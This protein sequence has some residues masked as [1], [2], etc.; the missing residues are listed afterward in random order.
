MKIIAANWKMNCDFDSTDFW[1]DNF[2][3]AYTNQYD[4]MKKVEIV[5]CPPSILL[6]YLDSELT[7]DGLEFLAEFAKKEGRNIDDF[8]AEEINEIVLGS[9]PFKLGGQDCHHE[10]S[11]SF[12]GDTSALMLHN[13]GCQYVILGHSERRNFHFESDQIISKKIKAALNQKIIP[14]ICV[15]E[16]KEIRDQAKHL[17]FVEKQILQSI[18]TDVKFEKLVI[19]YE[20]I[21][22]IG[23]G[24]IPSSTQILEMAN[25]IKKICNEKFTDISQSY[26]TL[27]GGSVSSKNSQEILAIS[28]IDGLLVG[29]ASLDAEEFATICI[30]NIN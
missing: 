29:K 27:Y 21:W 15:G 8:S 2:F 13:V 4:L 7:E 17:E 23:T 18:P 3:K 11:G 22:S 28:G 14:I 10:E 5:V 20:P 16:S 9:R 12:T 25:L 24:I 30:S 6:D 19:A 1:I 26:F